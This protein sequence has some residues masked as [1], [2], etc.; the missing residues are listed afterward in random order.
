MDVGVNHHQHHDSSACRLE[1]ARQ[2]GIQIAVTCASSS[3]ARPDLQKARAA[4][5]HT[6]TQGAQGHLLWPRQHQ[7]MP[8]LANQARRMAELSGRRIRVAIALKF[9]S[10][11]R[12]PR[13][14]RRSAALIRLAQSRARPD[15]QCRSAGNR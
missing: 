4:S 5:P 1:A 10:L 2:R 11:N 13:Q 7:P 6:S 12:V 15:C 3:N 9:L 14:M 8:I